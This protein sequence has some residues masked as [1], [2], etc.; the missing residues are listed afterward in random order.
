LLVLLVVCGI[1]FDM[2][3]SIF[4]D[5]NFLLGPITFSSVLGAIE[6]FGEMIVM[7]LCTGYVV[8]LYRSEKGK[9]DT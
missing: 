2:I 4:S 7:S 1:G 3:H 8:N 6:D 9:I 5:D